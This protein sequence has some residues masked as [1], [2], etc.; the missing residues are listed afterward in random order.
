M[1][2]WMNEAEVAISHGFTVS[3]IVDAADNIPASSHTSPKS[4]DDPDTTTTFGTEP[5]VRKK[6]FVRNRG[7][8]KSYLPLPSSS[9]SHSQPSSSVPMQA[10]PASVGCYSREYYLPLP[11]R[12]LSPENPNQTLQA[13]L[14]R[15]QTRLNNN[16]HLAAVLRQP[17]SDFLKRIQALPYIDDDIRPIITDALIEINAKL[18]DQPAFINYTTRG[19]K[20]KRRVSPWRRLKRWFLRRFKPTRRTPNNTNVSEY[21]V[22]V[23]KDLG[24]PLME[25]ERQN[26][27]TTDS[28]SNDHSSER[29]EFNSSNDKSPDAF[30]LG[31]PT[32]PP[33]DYDWE[34]IDDGAEATAEDD[35]FF[36][37]WNH[38]QWNGVQ[39][40]SIVDLGYEDV[41]QSFWNNVRWNSA[42]Y[43]SAMSSELIGMF[44]AAALARIQED[45][46]EMLE[47]DE[48]NASDWNTMFVAEDLV[49]DVV[50]GDY[51]EGEEDEMPISLWYLLRSGGLPEED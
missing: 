20:P 31:V 1:E 18:V 12:P 33:D 23:L 34:S 46:E 4:E 45:S 39:R 50:F 5:K 49:E 38:G 28:A 32:I 44:S 40:P 7:R 36:E 15:A 22:R 19:F 6:L 24:I 48:W 9:S 37:H 41:A 10:K 3:D 35:P 26:S 16:I 21:A 30:S 11:Q 2:E 13:L 25:I 43:N 47:A 27:T 17:I 51:E 42:K 14:H 8:R 29:D